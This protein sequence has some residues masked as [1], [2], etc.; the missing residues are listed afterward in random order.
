MDN[1]L[2]DLILSIRF[3]RESKKTCKLAKA[4]AKREEL[5]INFLTIK[6]LSNFANYRER[7]LETILRIKGNARLFVYN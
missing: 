7:V 6:L 3:F 4:G 1:L 2:N 5:G